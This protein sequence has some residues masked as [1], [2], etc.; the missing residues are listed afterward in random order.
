MLASTRKETVIQSALHHTLK[1]DSGMLPRRRVLEGSP[2]DAP[3]R[4]RNGAIRNAGG[5]AVRGAPCASRVFFL[6][7]RGDPRM[8]CHPARAGKLLGKVCAVMVG[9]D[10]SGLD[11]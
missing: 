7:R 11:R 4:R 9:G 1:T 2:T 10:S 5:Q 6:D 3:G 8:Q